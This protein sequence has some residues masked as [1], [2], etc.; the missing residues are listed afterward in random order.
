MNCQ[1]RKEDWKG[2]FTLFPCLPTEL[3]RD[4]WKL[5]ILHTAPWYLRVRGRSGGAPSSLTVLRS[6]GLSSITLACVEAKQEWERV[7]AELYTN[8][9]ASWKRLILLLESSVPVASLLGVKL[10]DH[11]L[12][13]AIRHT[14]VFTDPATNL[15]NVFLGLSNFPRLEKIEIFVAPQICADGHTLR[16]KDS[17]LAGDIQQDTQ[18]QEQAA[19]QGAG[20]VRLHILNTDPSKAVRDFYERPEA[21]RITVITPNNLECPSQPSRKWAFFIN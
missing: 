4:I 18:S 14:C 20:Q 3:R 6:P 13:D 11:G 5:A 21:P 12:R 9:K 8:K 15:S 1:A 19:G 2:L 17:E 7:E 16:T 10:A